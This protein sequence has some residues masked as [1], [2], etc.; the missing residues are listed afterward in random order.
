MNC[1]HNYVL[2]L[3]SQLHN[4][5]SLMQEG[6]TV[7]IDESDDQSVSCVSPTVCR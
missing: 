1:S 7:V 3:P 2:T 5:Q 4:Q 6:G